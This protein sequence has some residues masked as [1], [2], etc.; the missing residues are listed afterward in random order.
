MN[1]K[2]EKLKIKNF[3]SFKEDEFDFG[4]YRG[5][6]LV[7]G[8]NMDVPASKNAVGKS[9]LFSALLYVL[10][11]ELQY[12]IKNQNLRNRYSTDKIMSVELLFHA[13]ADRRFRLIRGLKGNAS[14]IDLKEI[15]ENENIIHDL[16]RSSIAETDKFIQREI[17]HCDISIFLRTIILSSDQNYNF[18]KLTP[19]AKRDFIE[20]L[21][22]ISTFGDMYQ[23]IHRDAL[24]LDKDIASKQSGILVLK[25]NDETYS[26]KMKQFE[27][28]RT[29][30]MKNI[31]SELEEY[32]KKYAELM[33]TEVGY[34]TAELS[35]YHSK[36]DEI[37]A[38]MAKLDK[39]I[40]TASD[41]KKKLLYSKTKNTASIDHKL[42]ILN[43]YDGL[44]NSVCEHCNPV[45]VKYFNLDECRESINQ[46]SA[47]SV[48]IDKKLKDLNAKFEKAKKNKATLDDKRN[49]II[50][51]IYNMTSK[52]KEI[53]K[54]RDA[55]QIKINSL[56]NSYDSLS[57][58]NNP[59]T[60]LVESNLQ[61]LSAETDILNQMNEKYSYLA[62][63]ENIV[64]ADTL[65]KFIVK[66]LVNL[67]NI[68]IKYYL[69]KLGGNFECEFDENMNCEFHTPG[70]N[71]DYANFSSGEQMR[72]MIA[73]CFAF[74]D[75]MQTRNNF[76]SNILILDEFIDSG[77]DSL[78]ITG[79]VQI[80]QDFVK[81][82]GQTI[83]VISHRTGDLDNSKFDSIIQVIKE[84]NFS[85]ITY[86][87]RE[88]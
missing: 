11:G 58:S 13:D 83:Y 64:A 39:F 44:L 1:L 54:Q 27:I 22:N 7:C 35:V 63:A 88:K 70:G 15:D 76:N 85:R 23:M 86:L 59:Y 4:E 53:N 52:S 57:A 66:D 43:G 56:S 45:I 10:F 71:C 33:S 20:K 19:A 41:K 65:K 77:I 72:L 79:V 38:A 36:V 3:M 37:N 16:N 68:K 29:E 60:D 69:A 31:K 62:M 25:G 87:P 28:E 8:K 51:Q 30:K 17:I 21:F 6:T 5:L 48:E 42:E 67:L 32:V 55:Y 74:K 84:K 81:M 46:L 26:Q 9:S 78:A 14:F 50:D 49:E 18:F 75:F 12:Q 34:D 82:H 24:K 73:T 80:L 47:D 40:D 2:I 61:N